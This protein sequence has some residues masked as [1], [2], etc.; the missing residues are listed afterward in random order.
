MRES[1]TPGSVRGVLSNEHPYRDSV[2]LLDPSGDGQKPTFTLARDSLP[3][4]RVHCL[5]ELKAVGKRSEGGSLCLRGIR[6]RHFQIARSICGCA[7]L[8]EP[9][10]GEAHSP[11]L[12]H[13][14]ATPRA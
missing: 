13:S 11:G 2:P 6:V 8:A 12:R 9:S 14:A 1:R 3:P 4:W 10:A 5:R 7:P